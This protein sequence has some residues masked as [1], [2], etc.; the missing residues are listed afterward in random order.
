M[1]CRFRR[2]HRLGLYIVDFVC[3]EHKL[4][5]EADGGQHGVVTAQQ[6]DETRTKWLQARGYRVIRF[7]NNEVLENCEGVLTAIQAELNASNNPPP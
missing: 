6:R 3:L 4:I 5:V 7:W 1:H 2:Q